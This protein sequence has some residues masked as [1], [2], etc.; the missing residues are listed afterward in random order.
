MKIEFAKKTKNAIIPT[1]EKDDAGFDFYLTTEGAVFYPSE[2]KLL[3]TGVCYNLPEGYHMLLRERGS[4]GKANIQVRAG[5]CDN[6]FTGEVTAF[7][8]NGD[9]RKYLIMCKEELFPDFFK[10][11]IKQIKKDF[12][13]GNMLI[14]KS[15][16]I[17]KF[18][19]YN[20][21]FDK[22]KE[23]LKDFYSFYPLEKAVCQGIVIKVDDIE[24]VEVDYIVKETN[25][26][27]GMLGSS[28]K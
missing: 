13:Y 10:E 19:Y 28:G 21:E 11:Y 20:Q 12:I 8:T 6:S 4:T 14:L 23:L 2:T 15:K 16:I 18:L 17:N 24:S 5:V 22:V 3:K 9:S 25:R 7:L 26:G 27:N 1:K